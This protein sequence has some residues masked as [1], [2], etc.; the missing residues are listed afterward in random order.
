VKEDEM[1]IK[2]IAAGMLLLAAVAPWSIEAKVGSAPGKLPSDLWG[3]WCTVKKPNCPISEILEIAPREVVKWT[4][5]ALSGV[6]STESIW[7]PSDVDDIY[8]IEFECRDG[9]RLTKVYNRWSFD[10]KRLTIS[11]VVNGKNITEIYVRR[12]VEK[13]RRRSRA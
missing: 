4:G 11:R 10:G 12:V 3:A 8:E 13:P 7:A 6:C 9:G 5:A 1:K 2:S